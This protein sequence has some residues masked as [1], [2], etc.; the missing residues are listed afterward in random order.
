[1]EKRNST[2][3]PHTESWQR[4]TIFFKCWNLYPT[5][6]R[7]LGGSVEDKKKVTKNHNLEPNKNMALSPM[8]V[9]QPQ[10]WAMHW[11]WT[12]SH[13]HVCKQT[14]EDSGGHF[15]TLL[16]TRRHTHQ[17]FKTS[18]EGTTCCK[19]ENLNRCFVT[20]LFPQSRCVDHYGSEPYGKHTQPHQM[21]GTKRR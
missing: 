18:R 10:C 13:E 20:L 3:G 6:W 5:F 9:S 11:L 8:T 17:P 21:S 14:V 12:L 2:N 15:A 4:V 1:M 7:S 19:R 16:R